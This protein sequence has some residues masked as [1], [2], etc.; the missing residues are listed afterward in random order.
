MLPRVV[1]GP[2]PSPNV[3]VCLRWIDA[4]GPLLRLLTPPARGRTDGRAEGRRGG[5][6]PQNDL[7]L[8]TRGHAAGR[9]LASIYQRRPHPENGPSFWQE[10][11]QINRGTIG[12]RGRGERENRG[13]CSSSLPCSSSSRRKM[14]RPRSQRARL[15]PFPPISMH[16]STFLLH[17]GLSLPL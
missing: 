15:S 1:V 11:N 9:L 4:E 10:A 6:S 17:V 8:A 5:I 7:P 13:S 3:T 2:Y 16:V 14:E 12:E